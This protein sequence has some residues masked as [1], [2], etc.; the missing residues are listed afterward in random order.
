MMIF[1]AANST[2]L[3]LLLGSKSRFL[4]MAQMG[5]LTRTPPSEFV[6]EGTYLS[7]ALQSEGL[8]GKDYLV[9]QA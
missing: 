9:A 4:L 8:A 5:K 7:N 2:C 6:S 1:Q 3:A